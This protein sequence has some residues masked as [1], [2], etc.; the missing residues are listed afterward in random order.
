MSQTDKI[1]QP[2]KITALL[3]DE[4][5]S[6]AAI[7]FA[8][9]IA[10]NETL[11]EKILKII[12][13]NPELASKRN[14]LSEAIIKASKNPPAAS[15]IIVEQVVEKSE[16]DL[17]KEAME[18]AAINAVRTDAVMKGA[19][20]KLRNA[21]RTQANDEDNDTTTALQKIYD[22]AE[23]QAEIMN[24]KYKE[25]KEAKVALTQLQ[26]QQGKPLA[27]CRNRR[28][29]KTKYSSKQ[30]RSKRVNK[31]Q[32]TKKSKLKSKLK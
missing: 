12:E 7:E 6:A 22:N 26:T 8:D 30:I 31:K 1:I 28:T 14:A 5:I 29:K 24:T 2:D 10:I 4:K 19:L 32:K 18:N 15:K 13:A 16:L 20:K 9:K 25:A 11:M 23:I 17:A 3:S 27:G 21:R